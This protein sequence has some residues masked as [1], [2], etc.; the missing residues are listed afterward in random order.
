MTDVNAPHTARRIDIPV[1]F[2]IKYVNAFASDD[3]GSLLAPNLFK[4]LPGM[5][6]AAVFVLKVGGI[7]FKVANHGV[8]LPLFRVPVRIVFESALIKLSIQNIT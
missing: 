3:N 4:T 8:C 7:V 2:R 6:Y 1:A 5:K